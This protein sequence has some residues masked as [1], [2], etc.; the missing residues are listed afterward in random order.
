MNIRAATTNDHAELRD[1]CR[2]ALLPI[3]GDEA[4]QIISLLADGP[5]TNPTLWLV[6]EDA[7]NLVGAVIGTVH[8]APDGIVTGY[9]D[10]VMVH[11]SMRQRRIGSALL[12]E[13][14]QRIVALGAER[15]IVGLDDPCYAWPGIDVRC[16]AALCFFEARGYTRT[17]EHIGT[18][19]D[20][21][22]LNLDTTTAEARLRDHGVQ[23]RRTTHAEAP[24][25]LRWVDQNWGQGWQWETAQGLN[26][27]PPH[28]HVAT[29]DGRYIGF[30]THGVHRSRMFGPIGTA[31]DKRGL[32][33]GSTL[34]LRCLADLQQ[35]GH[36][37]AA[38]IS[39]G[40]LAFYSRTVNAY[41]TRVHWE[42]R[43]ELFTR[44]D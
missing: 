37:V 13:L 6:A 4:D 39:T 33:I 24:D 26:G 5:Y 31:T 36:H 18:A 44:T 8:P 23:I 15:V 22:Q 12:D 28:A 1:L 30:A 35:R 25:F 20:L 42:Y 43:R 41:V 14:E 11:P 17:G 38:T 19:I 7:H 9:V 2:H 10:L 34:M 32:G 3:D 40:P 29:I 21:D 27:S 16:T